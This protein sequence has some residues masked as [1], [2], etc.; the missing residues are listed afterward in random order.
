MTAFW[1]L[2]K[3]RNGDFMQL[4]PFVGEFWQAGL[5]QIDE[6]TSRFA[7]GKIGPQERLADRS[8][9]LGRA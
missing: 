9:R 2:R 4:W 8:R 6:V 1:C 7:A 5:P 3:I